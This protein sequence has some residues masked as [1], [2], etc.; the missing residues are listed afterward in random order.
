MTKPINEQIFVT[1][2]QTEG[3]SNWLLCIRVLASER[4]V[5]LI[6]VFGGG[7]RLFV[8]SPVVVV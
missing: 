7:C 2:A 4:V 6:F 3:P 8:V 1:N 5:W